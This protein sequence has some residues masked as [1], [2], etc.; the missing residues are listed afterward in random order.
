V[1]GYPAHFIIKGGPRLS[2][3]LDAKEDEIA[4]CWVDRFHDT[5]L[6]MKFQLITIC[7]SWLTDK[8]IG[9]RWHDVFSLAHPAIM[10]FYAPFLILKANAPLVTNVS[11]I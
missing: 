6:R 1:P 7:R 2:L 8:S 11:D 4:D 5:F 10:G 3:T 9:V